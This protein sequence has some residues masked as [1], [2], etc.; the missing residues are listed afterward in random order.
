MAIRKSEEEEFVVVG[1]TDIW[2][3]KCKQALD[4]GGFKNI[5]HN[6][7]LNQ[8]EA[9]Y[10]TF[11]VVGSIIITLLPQNEK[12]VIKIKATGNMDNIFALIKSPNSVILSSFKDN[13]KQI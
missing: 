5:K 7:I 12:T 1:T 8:L 6:Q 9:D 3:E 11:K 2:A 10:K 13:I 4:A